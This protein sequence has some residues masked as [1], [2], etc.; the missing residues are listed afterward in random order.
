MMLTQRILLL[1]ALL[2]RSTSFAPSIHYGTRLTSSLAQYTANPLAPSTQSLIALKL[3]ASSNE[4]ESEAAPPPT[5]EEVSKKPASDPMPPPGMLRTP[6]A[7]PAKRLDPL[8]A[9]LTR[10]DPNA[11]SN[12]PK[13]Q[14]PLLGEVTLDKQLFIVVPIVAFAVLGFVFFFVVAFNSQDVFVDSINQWNDSV[15][16]PPAP[17]PL[18]PNE[19]RGLCSSQDKDLE[20][21]RNFMNGLG[22]K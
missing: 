3:S 19:C 20:G 14:I 21:L 4:E 17:V 22:G 5:P 7:V 15:M 6:P 12:A 11:N 13:T 8:L 2:H 9:S 1:V 16:N 18:D 10:V